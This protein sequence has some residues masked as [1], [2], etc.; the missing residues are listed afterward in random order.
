MYLKVVT[1][2]TSQPERS[3]L[4]LCLRLNTECMLVTAETSQ[5]RMPS[6]AHVRSA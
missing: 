6:D 3:S 2:P 5:S 1:L 4:K